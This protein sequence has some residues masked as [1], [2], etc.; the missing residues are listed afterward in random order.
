[1]KAPQAMS[2]YHRKPGLTEEVLSDGW[3]KTRDVGTM[4]ERGFLYLLGRTDEMI[5]SGGFNVSP[6]EVERVLMEHPCVEEAVA[7][8]VPDERWGTAV[9][10]VVRLRSGATTATG[11]LAEFVR[12][13]L[14]FRSP[15]RMTFADVIP[16]NA[17]GKL[18]RSR[19]LALLEVD[20][21]GPR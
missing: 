2:R 16:K 8:G 5:N 13:R 14:G 19:C 7:L 9:G 11:E 18:D 10:A 1:V 17:Y 4:D 12:P 20:G 6:R 3:I 15:N 21:R